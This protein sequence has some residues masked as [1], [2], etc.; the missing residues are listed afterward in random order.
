MIPDWPALAHTVSQRA[1]LQT[2]RNSTLAFAVNVRLSR[3]R[4]VNPIVHGSSC[5]RYMVV[6]GRVALWPEE[7]WDWFSREWIRRRKNQLPSRSCF[8]RRPTARRRCLSV[9]P[10]GGSDGSDTQSQ[11]RGSTHHG[12][13]AIYNYLVMEWI[14][15][16][17]LRQVISDMGQAN[18]LVDF[19]E[20][21]SWFKQVVRGLEAIHA[22]G[23]VHLDIK[24][25]NILISADRVG[26]LPT[27]GLSGKSTSPARRAQPRV[28]RPAL[29]FTWP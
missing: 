9:Q 14:D 8:R 2:A 11:D 22:S 13:A 25:S 21:S 15:G 5:L 12:R 7:A 29:C 23:M 3:S 19:N 17:S 28:T 18:R 16:S 1:S 4:R 20:A 10:R 27:S 24:P 6:I 26:E